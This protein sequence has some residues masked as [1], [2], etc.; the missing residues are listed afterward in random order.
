M[1]MPSK[2]WVSAMAALPLTTAADVVTN[3][4]NSVVAARKIHS[5]I[6]R[7]TLDLLTDGVRQV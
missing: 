2:M 6:A 5:M 4:G 1:V 3:L 7:P